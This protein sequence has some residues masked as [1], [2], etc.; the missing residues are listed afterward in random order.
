MYENYE[1]LRSKIRFATHPHGRTSGTFTDFDSLDDKSDDL[2]YY[3][4]FIKF[5]FGRAVR[6]A[7][8]LIQ[9]GHM[10]R[11]DGLALAKKYDGEFPSEH[12]PAMLEYL[13]MTEAELLET[14]DRHRNPE[15]WERRGDAWRLRFPLE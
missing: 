3:M 10:T 8:R 13:D 9:N 12:L 15:L 7:S 11:E 5:G 6:D 1:Y 14:I 2:Y 4:Q